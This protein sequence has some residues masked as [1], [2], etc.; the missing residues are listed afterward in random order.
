R[1]SLP[2]SVR[3]VELTCP[4]HADAVENRFHLEAY[5]FE[6]LVRALWPDAAIGLRSYRVDEPAEL[7]YILQL[8]ELELKI[9]APNR[10]RELLQ[11]TALT[12]C[13]WWRTSTVSG[14][15]S[16]DEAWETPYEQ[17][18]NT[19]MKTVGEPAWT[20]P[21]PHFERLVIEID[22]DGQDERLPVGHERLDTAEA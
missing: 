19:V 6:R 2:T 9:F 18:F 7:E 3:S 4:V 16:R 8:D 22:H 5:P 10:V 20:G 11:R 17:L 13:G 1:L 15:I 21:G 14:E 12:P